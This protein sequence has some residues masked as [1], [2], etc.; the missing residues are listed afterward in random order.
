[1]AGVDRQLKETRKTW[2]EQ[3]HPQWADKLEAYD[4]WDDV[5]YENASY[6]YYSVPKLEK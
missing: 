2:F 4:A 1:M 6:S 3:H 5:R